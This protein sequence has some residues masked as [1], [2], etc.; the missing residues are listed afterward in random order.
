MKKSPS[1][2]SSSS[3]CSATSACRR[4]EPNASKEKSANKCYSVL[5]TTKAKPSARRG[6]KAADLL[7]RDSQAT[8]RSG[9]VVCRFL[10]LSRKASRPTNGFGMPHT[11][12]SL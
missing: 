2:L 5:P 10:H 8:E 9:G 7:M 4:G 12:R 1:D 6:R 3:P 11:P